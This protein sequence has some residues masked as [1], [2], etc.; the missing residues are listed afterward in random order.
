MSWVKLDDGFYDNPTNRALGSAGRDTY[1]AGLCYCAKSLT[2]GRIAKTDIPLIVALAQTK[3][4]TV[5]KL[6]AAGRWI[7]R[8]DYYEVDQYLKYNPSREH[9]E[10]RRAEVSRKKSEAGKKGAQARWHPDSTS[11]GKG[12]GIEHGKPDGPVPSRPQPLPSS[13]GSNSAPPAEPT[14]D[15]RWSWILAE[16][17]AELEHPNGDGIRDRSRYL[18]RLAADH[19]ERLNDQVTAIR[20]QHPNW[21]DDQIA[22]HVDPDTAP[23]HPQHIGLE[24]A[25][26]EAIEQH[27]Q[28]AAR[29]QL[30]PMTTET[31]DAARNAIHR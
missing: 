25:G 20:G 18:A 23:V 2:D 11:H 6:V 3:P 24:Q 4:A 17:R 9:T 13:H 8:G 29:A 22:D 27:R 26:Q 21:T 15:D 7:D 14:D 5:K 16:R 12:N 28:A 19:Y 30:E 10:E 1:I 31:F